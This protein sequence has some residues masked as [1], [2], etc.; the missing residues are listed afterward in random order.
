VS[1]RTLVIFYGAVAAAV[2]FLGT[3]WSGIHEGKAR[4][5]GG[6]VVM[7]VAALGLL[8][9]LLVAGRIVWVIGRARRLDAARRRDRAL[10]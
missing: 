6:A 7:A 8:A 5:V 10:R 2:L 9:S 3:V 4:S 1:R